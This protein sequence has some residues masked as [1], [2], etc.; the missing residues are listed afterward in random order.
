MP[1]KKDL[2]PHQVSKGLTYVH[3]E[4]PFLSKLKGQQVEREKVSSKF[5]NYEDGQDDEDYDELEGAQVVELD[6]HGKEI[7]KDTGEES[8]EEVAEEKEEEGPAVDE[9]GRILFRKQTKRD[10]KGDSKRKLKAII[11]E[12]IASQPNKNKKKKKVVKTSL[13]SFDE[14]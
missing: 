9:N 1:P 14:E 10:K 7:H 12:S 13:L 5:L 11:D 6:K 4:A 8:E 2:T 3:K